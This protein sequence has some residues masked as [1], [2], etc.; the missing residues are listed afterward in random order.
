VLCVAFCFL[1]NHHQAGK[2]P[3]SGRPRSFIHY[4]FYSNPKT[5]NWDRLLNEQQRGKRTNNSHPRNRQ[6]HQ[7]YPSTVNLTEIKFTNEIKFS[8]IKILSSLNTTIYL[9][10]I[11]KEKTTTCFGTWPSSGWILWFCEKEMLSATPCNLQRLGS[12]F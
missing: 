5:N 9:D 1:P 7:F 6:H 10:V 3:V 2:S 4:M 8:I 12:C 11:K